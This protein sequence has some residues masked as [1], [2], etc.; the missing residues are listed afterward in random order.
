MNFV[1]LLVAVLAGLVAG[2][3]MKHVGYGRG[4]DIALGLIGSV[5]ASWIF[6][7]RWVSPDPGTM[8]VILVAAAG[9]GVLIVARRTIFPARA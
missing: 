8:A 4:W 9:A 6:Q 1:M 5:V 7:S 3:V 2:Y